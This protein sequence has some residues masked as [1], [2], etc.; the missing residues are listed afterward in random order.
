MDKKIT[1]RVA[2]GTA[3]TGLAVASF[4]VHALRHRNNESK[5]YTAWKHSWP[6][7]VGEIVPQIVPCDGHEPFQCKL[8]PK[9]GQTG[10]MFLMTSVDNFFTDFQ[11]ESENI[12]DIY[13]VCNYE[14]EVRRNGDK[15]DNVVLGRHK[16][17][18][19]FN[20][21]SNELVTLDVTTDWAFLVRDNGFVGA[22]MKNGQ[23]YPCSEPDNIVKLM[24]YGT[25]M[26]LG[27]DMPFQDFNVGD[28]YPVKIPTPDLIFSPTNRR[29][30]E[31]VKINGDSCVHICTNSQMDNKSILDFM[32]SFEQCLTDVKHR[33]TKKG[34]QE[35]IKESVARQLSISLL[36]E[37][38]YRL[39]DGMLVFS[40]ELRT[41]HDNKNG[42]DENTV[43]YMRVVLS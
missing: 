17:N 14:I 4:G 11:E 23:Y 39:S 38:Y 6:K 37:R 36:S 18:R 32:G 26:T 10:S 35:Q 1:R 21:M 19:L 2:F 12:P 22:E 20:P 7:M 25:Q 31:I 40:K 16:G 15:E 34:I 33:N 30:A 28:V 8:D 42:K 9:V 5:A 43:T 13:V 29:I 24:T 27:I 41:L 3:I